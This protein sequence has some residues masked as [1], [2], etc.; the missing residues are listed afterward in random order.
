MDSPSGIKNQ[1]LPTTFSR[2][3]STAGHLVFSDAFHV[4]ESG[5]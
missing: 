4:F 2:N 1:L 3:E 5:L